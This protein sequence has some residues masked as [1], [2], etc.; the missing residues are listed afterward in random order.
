MGGEP[1]KPPARKYKNMKEI[2]ILGK[3]KSAVECPFDSE[4][5]ATET[6]LPL[7]DPD[8]TKVFSFN[9]YHQEAM[10]IAQENNI[11]VVST[12]PYATETFPYDGIIKEFGI[13]Y[14]RPTESY[15][16]AYAIYLGYEKLKLYGIDFE[17]GDFAADKARIMFWVGVAKGKGIEVEIAKTSKLYRV[18]KEN[19]KSRYTLLRERKASKDFVGVAQDGVDP[20]CFVTAIDKSAVTFASYDKDGREIS[21]WH[22]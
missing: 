6:M 22:S 16:I 10:D 14:F 21:K 12:K 4:L 9:G 3:G 11:P 7:I 15:M 13:G 17:T 20:Y 1:E 2:I 5:W 19:V 18:L 8:C